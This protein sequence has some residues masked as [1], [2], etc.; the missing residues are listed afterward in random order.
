MTRLVHSV[1]GDSADAPFYGLIK[2][3]DVLTAGCFL[4]MVVV[5]NL[6]AA[7]YLMRKEQRAK[8]ESPRSLRAHFFRASGK[9]VYLT[10][11]IFGCYI[12]AQPLLDRLPRDGTFE[13]AVNV[14]DRLL[15]FGMML[16]LLWA[17]SRFSA[18]FEKRLVAWSLKHKRRWDDL[19][20]PLIA[21]SVRIL[22]PVIGVFL[23]LQIFALPS[24]YA[25]IANRGVGIMLIVS[26]ALIL[27]QS[28]GFGE[29]AILKRFDITAANNLEARK[30]Y[31]QVHV[32]SKALY[33]LIS[34]FTVA[35]I[36]MLFEQVRHFGASILASAG[37]VGVILG[38]AAQKTIANLFAGFQLAMTQPIRIDDVVVVEGQWGRIE[39]IT[40][41]YV[42]I[43]IWDER[44]LVV[45][46]SY[47]NE[48]P[49]EN[50]TRVS[51]NLL[52]SV[53]LW[54][55]YT[56]PLEEARLFLKGVIES[57]PLW[58]KRFWNLQVTD[59]TEKS[60][61]IRVLV[62]SMDSSKNFDLRCHVRE[63]LIVFIQKQHPQSL[64]QVRN[65]MITSQLPPNLK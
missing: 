30:V 63:A 51:A 39:E 50:W 38:F 25:H 65:Q 22:L 11:W 6:F 16:M 53:M 34:I 56:L 13:T 17:A 7:L 5:L 27:I 57:H 9:P 59:A 64:P 1:F 2:W 58:D 36:L 21:R 54:V 46:L 10:L 33:F 44:R 40:L 29:K 52:G 60:M 62:T 24:E 55:D 41:T 15:D 28:V 43:R 61:Q 48:K 35:S 18:V 19:L 37:V 14:A 31:T 49:F 20:V 26:V 4:L 42:I 45:P 47:F 8:I 23:S 3:G 32:I 12:A